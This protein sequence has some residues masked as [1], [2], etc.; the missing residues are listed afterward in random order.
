MEM[1]VKVPLPWMLLKMVMDGQGV[2]YCKYSQLLEE[3]HSRGYVRE[4]SP[5]ADLGIMLKVFN[6]L[7][8]FY[9]KVPSGCKKED[10]LVFIDPGF[11]YSATSDF[12]MAAKEEIEDSSEEG[13]HQTQTDDNQGNSEESQHRTQVVSTEETEDCQGGSEEGQHQ[14]QAVS[15]EETEGH[16]RDSEEV[17][18]QTQAASTEKTEDNQGGSEEGQHQTHAVSTEKTEDSQGGS[19]EGQHQTQAVSTEETEGHQRGSEEGQ[20]QTH[21]VSTEKTEDSQ[22]GSKE[23][24]HQTQAASRKE[25][26][27]NHGDSRE[28]K[29]HNVELARRRMPVLHLANPVDKSKCH[30]APHLWQ[31]AFRERDST[32]SRKKN[33]EC[34][35]T[36]GP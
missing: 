12:L 20:H 27:G 15:T 17:Q 13:P 2:R 10:S 36:K 5:D 26:E 34:T 33:T 7:G 11:L 3:A 1:P 29:L 6:A 19:K 4:G 21:A 8:L 23:G 30:E 16:Q 31:L 32:A 22:G 25:T 14:T 18:H 9:H 24:Q 28:E 35:R